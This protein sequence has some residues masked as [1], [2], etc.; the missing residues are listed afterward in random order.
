M[1]DFVTIRGIQSRTQP[2]LP[3]SSG[4]QKFYVQF[5]PGIVTDVCLNKKSAMYTGPADINCIIAKPHIGV[6][7]QKSMSRTKYFPL[8]R[9]M[10]DVPVKGDSVLLCDFGG[11][12]Y[13]MGPLNSMNSPNFNVDVLNDSV[14]PK[15]QNTNVNT[16]ASAR[17]AFN[18]PANYFIAPIPRLEK[19]YKPSLDDP[20]DSNLGEDNSIQKID[21]HGDMLFEGRYGNSIRIGSRGAYPMMVISNGRNP[22]TGDVENMFDGSLISITSAGSLLKHFKRF[23]LASDS[24]EEN[25]RLVA[26]GN[27]SEETQK[28]DYNFGNDE[29]QKVILN[30]QILMNSDKITI[31][32]REN[33]IT[34]SSLLNLDFGAGNNLTINTKNYTSI[35]SS[36]IYLGKQARQKAIDGGEAEPLVLGIQLRE[37]LEE[38]VGIVETLKVTGVFPGISGPIDPGTISKIN[39]IK[40]KLANPT[41]FSEY[42][43]IEDNGQKT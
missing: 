38:L 37:L 3:S 15:Y 43:F 18:I 30:N 24:V 22:E 27:D 42:H 14:N 2:G 21:T 41:F 25:T 13:Y 40:Q 12:D 7:S 29:N 5:I 20:L 11:I 31:N 1:G 6:S 26:G 33:N 16:K 36:N 19:S 23:T 4:N 34:L 9:G 8:F 28:F 32:A 10:I 35:E 39:S 17:A